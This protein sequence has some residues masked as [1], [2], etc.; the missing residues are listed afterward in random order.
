[1]NPTIPVEAVARYPIPGTVLP[2]AVRF[3]P[4]NEWLTY[5]DS[6]DNS[7][8]KQLYRLHLES[9]E[10]KLLADAAQVGS[11]EDNISLE[12]KLR[13]E[14]LRQ[15]ALGI[16][17]YAWSTLGQIL[18]PLP[19]GLFILDAPGKPLRQLI[20]SENGA[21]QN[22]RFSPNGK[23]VS[24]VQND[25][26]HLIPTEGGASQQL[27]D[28][29]QST[30]KMH[31]LAEYIAQE[32]MGRTQGYWWAPNSQQIA[33]TEVDEQHIPV[34]RIMHQG[35]DQVGD[36]AQEDHRYPFAGMPNAKVR[37]AVLDIEEKTPVWMDLG[38][39][40]DIYLAR[41]H[42]AGN[43]RLL[44]QILNREQTQLRLLSFDPKTGE[45][46]ELLQ[47][48]SDVW[49]NLNNQ[50]RVIK[51]HEELPD[52]GFVWAS[53]KTG[54]RHLYL[55]DWS[56]KEIR[57]LTQGDWMIDGLSAID[58]QKK[59]IYFTATKESPTEKHLYRTSFYDQTISKITTSPGMHQVHLNL[60]KQVFIDIT[61]DIEAPYSLS[62]RAL[63]DTDSSKQLFFANDEKIE[64]YQLQTPQIVSFKNRTGETLFGTIYHPP[65]SFGKGPFPTIVSV[66][67]GPHAQRVTNQWTLTA[68]LRAQFLSQHGFLVFKCDNRGSARR[69]LAFEGHIKHDMGNHEVSDQVDGVHWLVEQGLTDL[70]QVG[71]YGWSY[72]GYM[73]L[74]CL[75][76]AGDVF[77]TA[78]SGA[79]VTHWDG[80]D[81]C[82]TERYMGLPQQNAEGYEKSSVMHHI[83]KINGNLM[84]IHGLIDENVH[85]R[86]TARLINALIKAR[87]P[88]DLRLFPDERH[89]PRGLADRI[90]ME[91]QIK[92]YFVNTLIAQ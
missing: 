87:K 10:I 70:N 66:Y 14:R 6:N 27:T 35:K 21:I 3:S 72:G 30:G 43:G 1:M 19:T 71:V 9:G 86:H 37:L 68:D 76:Q 90:Y 26:I 20:S 63:N 47:E 83:D 2:S 75:A 61:S 58:H 82:Y 88:Y 67:G 22:G 25:E 23:C 39:D 62:L 73:A 46:T 81:T 29:A 74:M 16:T 40:E 59:Q 54:Y 11:T 69:G 18:I 91:E 60:A 50:F 65:S 17:Q 45:A 32:E 49:I 55:Y 89:S 92:D 57:Q 24:Y 56:G 85:F 28:G 8:T 64:E 41:V 84:I 13:R 52:G 51:P 34:Y 48:N 44:A 79:P 77:K 38:E 4:D 31:G 80:Y 12:E 53:E 5:L 78:V 36:G 33:F 42:W 7:L 15:R